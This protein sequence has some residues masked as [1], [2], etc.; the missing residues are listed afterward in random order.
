MAE[1]NQV[2]GCHTVEAWSQNF[3]KGNESKKL[4][5][6]FNNHPFS[7]FFPLFVGILFFLFLFYHYYYYWCI[8]G[9]YAWYN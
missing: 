1:V 5:F 9:A 7:F 3:E 4:V 2:I 8:T 6:P